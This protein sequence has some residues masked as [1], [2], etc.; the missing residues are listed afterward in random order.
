MLSLD[1]PQKVPPSELVQSYRILVVEDEAVIRDMISLA[2]EEQGYHI[3]AVGDGRAALNLLQEAAS[4]EGNTSPFDLIV[5]D[6]MLPQ[7]NGLDLCRLLR[8]Q[9][10]HVPILILSAKASARSHR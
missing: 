7:V 8:Y 9:N 6:L 2:L 4:Q 10:N 1:L 3:S 5:L